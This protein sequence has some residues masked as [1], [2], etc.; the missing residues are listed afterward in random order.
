MVRLRKTLK[1]YSIHLVLHDSLKTF[2]LRYGL[3][4]V[5]CTNFTIQFDELQKIYEV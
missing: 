2:L 5:K 4:T 1:T 3:R